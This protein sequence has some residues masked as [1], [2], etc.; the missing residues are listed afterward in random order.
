MTGQYFPTKG[1][2]VKE[3]RKREMK[4]ENLAIALGDKC[5][6]WA[7]KK[8]SDTQLIDRP[9]ENCDLFKFVDRKY[10]NS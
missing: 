7:G 4:V 5:C 8:L 1:L 6:F 9:I 2:I 10:L 3:E